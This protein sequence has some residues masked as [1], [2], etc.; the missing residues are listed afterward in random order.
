MRLSL[1][2]IHKPASGFSLVEIMVGMVIGMLGLIVIMQVFALSEGRKRTTTGGSDAMTEGAIAMYALQREI[3]QG[4]YGVAAMS[5]FGCSVITPLPTA[6]GTNALG[7]SIVTNTPSVS[8]PLAPVTINP[9]T[10]TIPPTALIPAGDPNTDTLLVFY[11]QT[12]TQTQGQTDSVTVAD[13]TYYIKN[14]QCPLASPM[15]MTLTN[16]TLEKHITVSVFSPSVLFVLGTSTP[17]STPLLPPRALAYAIRGGNL[18]V[19]DFMSND[20]SDDDNKNIPTIWV[21]IASNIV[22]LRAQYGRASVPDVNPVP[23]PA[24]VTTRMPNYIVSTYDQA[25]PTTSC[26]WA[27]TG[28]IRLAL[29]ARSGQYEKVA[30]TTDDHDIDPGLALA[31]VWDGKADAP[32]NLKNPD[33]PDNTDWKHYRYKM[34]QTTIPLVNVTW[35]GQQQVCQT[36]C[37]GC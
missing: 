26:G 9:V 11:A 23:D 14:D 20:C 24:D 18:T 27:R 5:L 15:P 1:N 16:T 13:N 25:T 8:I 7:V 33:D 36:G 31:P 32:I 2:L 19:C 34:F 17:D 37:V 30:V 21:P 35:M 6:P 12:T 29:V 22:S 3:R 28:A 10:A 4:G